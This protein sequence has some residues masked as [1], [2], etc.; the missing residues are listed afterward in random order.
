LGII[1]KI[2]TKFIRPPPLHS[3]C[4]VGVGEGRKVPAIG[5]EEGDSE[6]ENFRFLPLNTAA[7]QFSPLK[8]ATFYLEPL[9]LFFFSKHT[10]SL[11]L[12]N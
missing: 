11:I 1:K 9:N 2:Q 12:F 5:G 7:S 8:P 4:V 3:A 10:L 6:E